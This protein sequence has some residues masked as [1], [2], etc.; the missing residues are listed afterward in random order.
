MTSPD[1]IVEKTP[2]G[3]KIALVGVSAAVVSLSVVAYLSHKYNVA[4]WNYINEYFRTHPELFV[5]AYTNVPDC[6]DGSFEMKDPLKNGTGI[7]T[8]CRVIG[9]AIVTGDVSVYDQPLYNGVGDRGLTLIVEDEAVVSAENGAYVT[10]ETAD[11]LTADTA[12]ELITAPGNCAG[13]YGCGAWD[14]FDIS[15]NQVKYLGV[16]SLKGVSVQNPSDSFLGFKFP[17]PY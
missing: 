6:P 14:V 1:Q 3:A 16:Q 11:N 15:S 13:G 9:P 10:K 5:D 12:K 4:D 8:R 2:V 7:V 17:K